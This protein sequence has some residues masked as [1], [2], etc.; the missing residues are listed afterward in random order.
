MTKAGQDNKYG[1][2][3]GCTCLMTKARPASS[4]WM[5]AEHNPVLSLWNE[6]HLCHSFSGQISM[7]GINTIMC[8]MVSL[9]LFF[10]YYD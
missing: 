10:L 7:L 4:L 8:I 6:C 1:S 2:M 3:L 9:R 5:R